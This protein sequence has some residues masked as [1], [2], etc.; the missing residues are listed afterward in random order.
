LSYA[1]N[2]TDYAG[3]SFKKMAF[4]ID[5]V[6][7]F[8]LEDDPVYQASRACKRCADWPN[9][10]GQMEKDLNVKRERGE[11]SK[12]A[13][14]MAL[15]KLNDQ[16]ATQL[17]ACIDA[18]IAALNQARWNSGRLSAR[19]GDGR[20]RPV[21]AVPACALGRSINL[22]VQYP[23]GEKGLAQISLR[24]GRHVLDKSSLGAAL[25]TFRS[26]TL[27]TMR[28]SCGDQGEGDL[29]AMVEVSNA[30]SSAA[31]AYKA[32]FCTLSASTKNSRKE[33]G[34]NF[35]WAATAP[36]ST[37]RNKPAHCPR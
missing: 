12:E 18:D 30:R 37:A 9:E 6:Y 3:Q 24:C 35:S 7:F 8:K 1:Q 31:G 25:P 36:A 15:E 34:W 28:L 33:R 17:T 2:Q 20:I 22:N 5:P 21:L 4:A 13:C 27:A 29:R 11:S 23:M 16:R 10:L 32:P 19:F 14:L 26:S